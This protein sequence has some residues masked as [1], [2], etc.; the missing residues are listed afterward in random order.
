MVKLKNSAEFAKE[1]SKEDKAYSYKENPDVKT[2]NKFQ[3]KAK[4]RG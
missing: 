3:K 2:R 4:S 1:S